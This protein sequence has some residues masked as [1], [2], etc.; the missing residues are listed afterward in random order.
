M[1]SSKPQLIQS[2]FGTDSSHSRHTIAF[3]GLHWLGGL[4]LGTEGWGNSL[5]FHIGCLWPISGCCSLNS[6]LVSK[7]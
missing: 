4:S 6:E 3:S 5:P 1:T 7:R 2:V